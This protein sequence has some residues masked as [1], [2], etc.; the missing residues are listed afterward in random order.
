M[1]LVSKKAKKKK[2]GKERNLLPCC[3]EAF[4]ARCLI[5]KMM[6]GVEMVED[7][8]RFPLDCRWLCALTT[9]YFAYDTERLVFRSFCRPK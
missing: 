7:T 4:G 1:R 2:V 6:A 8:S 9:V 5:S 3:G